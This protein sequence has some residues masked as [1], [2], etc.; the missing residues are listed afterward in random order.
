VVVKGLHGHEARSV[1]VADDRAAV[2]GPV[3]YGFRSFDRQW[4][5]PDNRLINRPNPALW[6]MHSPNQIYLTVPSDRSPTGGPAV[7]L[8]SLIPDLH[9]YSGRGGRAIP[10]WGAGGVT[11]NVRPGLLAHL[12]ARYARAVG[13]EEVIA[14]VAAVAAHPGFT[15]RFLPDLATPGLRIPFT[16]DEA[17]FREAVELGRLVAWLHTFGER[18]A[19]PARG[20]PHAPPRLPASDAPT[21]PADGAI[22]LDPGQMPDAI[23]YDATKRRLLVGRG[24]VE[25][26]PLGVWSYEV[27][28]TQVL[29]HWFSY[30]KANR[31]RPI[32]GDRRK[33]SALGEIQ[34]DHWLPEYTSELI[35]L[36]HVLGWLV[37]LEPAQAE[38]LDRMCSGPLIS[39]DELHD[40]GAFALAPA[41]TRSRSSDHSADQTTLL[42]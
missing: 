30:R 15:E 34:P 27:S 31:E 1:A 28:G 37:R 35:N 20:R 3:R 2:I 4:L 6:E 7:T 13:P 19:D 9:H 16:A 41:T 10:L 22:P 17:M 42:V 36:L 8:T 25:N 33:P 29:R 26:V 39:E 18:F 38:L 32:I 23:G 12:A 40:A 14:Y 11:S 24:Y 21:I 5:I